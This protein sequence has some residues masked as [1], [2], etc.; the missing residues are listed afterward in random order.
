ME[1]ARSAGV[2]PPTP[3]KVSGAESRQE[4]ASARTS[5]L[6]FSLCRG[7]SKRDGVSGTT[8]FL[9]LFFS[10]WPPAGPGPFSLAAFH[11]PI[12][13]DLNKLCF[14]DEDDPAAFVVFRDDAT[15]HAACGLAG[16]FVPLQATPAQTAVALRAHVQQRFLQVVCVRWSFSLGGNGW[17][18]A[19]F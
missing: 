16:S 9:L 11:P 1:Q 17:L 4:A 3:K 8:L 7:L 19:P 5:I 10:G 13:E 6:P 15:V 14:L 18:G 12:Q 2:T